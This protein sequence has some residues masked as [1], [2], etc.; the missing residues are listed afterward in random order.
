MSGN[1]VWM[2]KVT[3]ARAML[4]LTKSY[5]E[6]MS[7]RGLLPDIVTKKVKPTSPTSMDIDMGKYHRLHF[8]TH[9]LQLSRE[10]IKFFMLN[11][12]EHEI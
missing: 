2:D 6:A 10:V 12:A 3:A 11:S 8:Q 5:N 1:V 4:K 7:E 9:M